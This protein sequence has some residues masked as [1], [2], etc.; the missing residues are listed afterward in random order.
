MYIAIYLAIGF[1]VQLVYRFKKDT[2]A[3]ESLLTSLVLPEL[4]IVRLILWP[5]YFVDLV[6]RQMNR[7]RKETMKNIIK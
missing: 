5:L 6:R 1:I 7:S 2:F 3:S 4:W